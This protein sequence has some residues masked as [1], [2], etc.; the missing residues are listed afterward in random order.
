MKLANFTYTKSDGSQSERA[1][2]V[3]KHPQK[4]Y[5][6]LDLSDL[7]EAEQETVIHVMEDVEYNKNDAMS[8]IGDLIKWRTFKPEG[9][10]WHNND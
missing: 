10:E 7:T 1:T 6:M 8:Q 4:N 9:I 3:I 5:L 2:I